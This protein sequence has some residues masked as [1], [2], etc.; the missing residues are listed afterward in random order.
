MSLRTRRQ[1]GQGADDGK[2][3]VEMGVTM[4]TS[5]EHAEPRAPS[6]NPERECVPADTLCSD[7]GLHDWEPASFRSLVLFVS[8]LAAGMHNFPGQGSNLRHSSNL[9]HS[10]DNTGSTIHSATQEL[11]ASAVLSHPVCTL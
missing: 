9:S 2:T 1:G 6:W 7:A 10:T 8:V 11:V 5:Q 3:K 4:A